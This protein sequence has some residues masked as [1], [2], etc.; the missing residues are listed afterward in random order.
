MGGDPSMNELESKPR[1]R[2]DRSGRWSGGGQAFLRNVDHAEKR[3]ELLRG[4]RE[5]I[6]I[7]ARNVPPRG[8]IPS[9][10]FVLAPQNAWP[11]TPS[12][13]GLAEL[14]R[15]AGLRVASEILF[16]RAIGVMRISSSI[17]P[18]NPNSSPVIHNVLDMG[19]EHDFA[20]SSSTPFTEGAAG[21]FIT[22]GS[23]NSYRNLVTLIGGY[24]RYRAAGGRRRLWIAGPQGSIGARR[25]IEIAGRDVDGLTIH[26]R[27]ISRAE[28]LSALR[29][30][31]AVVL[32]SKIE[33]SPVAALEAAVSNPNVV[34]SRIVGHVEILSEYGRVPH[35]CLFD[36]NSAADI[37]D[38]LVVA[39]DHVDR[40]TGL[41]AEC[42]AALSNADTR[43]DARV[44]WGDR[45]ER[46]LRCL[47][48]PELGHPHG[49]KAPLPSERS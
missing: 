8:H 42:N 16:R 33:S 48:V 29:N 46:W 17:P 18:I 21:A 47:D 34:L 12:F 24:R 31:A 25:E 7:I 1:F 37:H 11:W 23:M 9:G 20:E 15:V 44:S 3:H 43:E 38:A 45:V 6:P 22:L 13:S 26:W 2:F 41:L 28:C 30:A 36:P 39:E 10:P 5:A 49:L 27:S 19:F 14:R 32:P 4:G 35:Q 40:G